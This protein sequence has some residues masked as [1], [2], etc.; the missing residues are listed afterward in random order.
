MALYK[1]FQDDYARYKNSH[2]T[3]I[4]QT[5]IGHSA[6]TSSTANDREKVKQLLM[7]DILLARKLAIKASQFHFLESKSILSIC[8]QES[9][10]ELNRINQIIH[11][12]EKE[13]KTHEPEQDDEINE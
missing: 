9:F 7:E 1:L 5:R 2:D 10:K 3:L 12:I 13:Q 4:E 8:E 11:Q 6:S